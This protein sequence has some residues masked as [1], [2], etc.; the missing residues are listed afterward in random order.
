MINRKF[1]DKIEH[2]Y[3]HSLEKYHNGS[4]NE[5]IRKKQVLRF[6][7]IDWFQLKNVSFVCLV[8]HSNEP[9]SRTINVFWTIHLKVYHQRKIVTF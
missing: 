4:S 3:N 8:M 7:R 5:Y 2:F 1:Y 9:K 6:V